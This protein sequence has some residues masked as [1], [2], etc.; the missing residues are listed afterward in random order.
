[1]KRIKRVREK[2]VI[3]EKVVYTEKVLVPIW[4]QLVGVS[5]VPLTL[6]LPYFLPTPQ[7]IWGI[8][9]YLIIT[10]TTMIAGMAIAF[11]TVTPKQMAKNPDKWE[12]VG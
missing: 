11:R 6:W 3:P 7:T 5:L 4:V 9:I 12:D 8:V 2:T 10:M 1:M